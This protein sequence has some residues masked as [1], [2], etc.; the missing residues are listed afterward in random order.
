MLLL[1][2]CSSITLCNLLPRYVTTHKF[3]LKSSLAMTSSNTSL[4]RPPCSPLSV[5]SG[6]DPEILIPPMGMFRQSI[7]TI[8]V[9]LALQW[10]AYIPLEFCSN[11]VLQQSFC[12]FS[13]SKH[14]HSES[15][16]QNALRQFWA[17]LASLKGVRYLSSSHASFSTFSIPVS[18]PNT[19]SIDAGY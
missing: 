6:D 5:V 16:L 18:Q 2:L 19:T 11:W 10:P 3:F 8:K 15:L 1:V 13:H 7:T 9:C 4:H 14:L 17:L 12:Q